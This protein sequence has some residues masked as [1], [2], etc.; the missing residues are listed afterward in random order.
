M[1][2]IDEQC[3]VLR[4]QILSSVNAQNFNEFL[5]H[6]AI[7]EAYHALD[8]QLMLTY[9]KNQ[10]EFSISTIFA[11]VEGIRRIDPA[12]DILMLITRE[13]LKDCTE[14]IDAL[15]DADPRRN[16]YMM[17]ENRGM[18]IDMILADPACKKPLIHAMRDRGI[19]DA[20]V[21]KTAVEEMRCKHPVLIEGTL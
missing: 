4:K 12:A 13:T 5:D 1:I 2:S 3:A 21:L 7:N 8:L 6:H 17:H 9:E 19:Y 20:R 11:V 18:V 16:G 10:K 15:L 14:A